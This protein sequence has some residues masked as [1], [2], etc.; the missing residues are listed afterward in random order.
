MQ[1][2]SDETH[3]RAP[4]VPVSPMGRMMHAQAGFPIHYHSRCPAEQQDAGGFHIL[5]YGDSAPECAEALDPWRKWIGSV[6]CL[7][8]CG[9]RMHTI[10]SWFE[11]ALRLYPWQSILLLDSQIRPVRNAFSPLRTAIGQRGVGIVAPQVV[12]GSDGLTG[13]TGTTSF[14]EGHQAGWVPLR[15][16][17]IRWQAARE[18]GVFDE[19]FRNVLADVDYCYTARAIGWTTWLAGEAVWRE[20]P[21]GAVRGDTD[22]NGTQ[23]EDRVHFVRKWS[24]SVFAQLDAEV[25]PR[26]YCQ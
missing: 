10:N 16:M 7:R 12:G 6:T 25:F 22:F 8:E 20:V 2:K 21:P 26:N 15:A 5:I 19:G 11:E 9:G 24:G 13:E 1:K 4:I 14:S 18:V 23:R 17:A 3:H